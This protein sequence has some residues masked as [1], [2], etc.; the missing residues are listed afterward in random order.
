MTCGG[1]ATTLRPAFVFGG[2]TT[3][4]PTKDQAEIAGLRRE[5]E[6]AQRRLDP[7]KAA[8]DIMARAHALLEEISE[9]TDSERPR[10]K[11]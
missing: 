9:S 8:L 6:L 1:I 10:K 3:I 2:P 7:T 5:L 4:P 11:P